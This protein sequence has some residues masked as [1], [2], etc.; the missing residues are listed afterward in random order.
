[1]T[2]GLVSLERRDVERSFGRRSCMPMKLAHCDCALF[3]LSLSLFPSL[4]VSSVVPHQRREKASGM[5]LTAR[6][7]STFSVADR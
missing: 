6:R 2:S 5:T 3:F 1:M 7:R 4:S